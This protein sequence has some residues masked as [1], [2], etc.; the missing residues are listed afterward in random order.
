MEGSTMRTAA[1]LCLGLWL[2]LLATPVI[3]QD[4]PWPSLAADIFD[5]KPIADANGLVTLDAPYRAEDAALVPLTIRTQLPAGDSRFVRKVTLVVDGN[6]SPVAAEFSFGPKAAVDELTTRVRVDTYT[7]IHVV[8]ELSDGALYGTQ[9]FVKASGGCSAPAGKNPDEA[10]ANLGKMRLRQFSLP[11]EETGRGRRE[12]QLMI[13]HPNNSGLQMDQ[14]TRNYVPLYIVRALTIR[15]GEDL[16]MKMEGGISI[17]E[18]PNFRLRFTSNGVSKL[19][20][21]AEDTA[22]KIFKGDWRL[23][24]QPS[25][26]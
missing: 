3:A 23:E 6:P 9:K 24:A 11:A 16:V 8:A 10:M 4:D 19:E 25:G 26:S 17:S 1:A 13:R 5:G 20:V 2:S 7:N 21:E 18:D 12:V 22:G 15:Q 14:V